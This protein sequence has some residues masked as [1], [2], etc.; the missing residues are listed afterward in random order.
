MVLPYAQRLL[1]DGAGRRRRR[2]L[3]DVLSLVPSFGDQL[4]GGLG[5]ALQPGQPRLLV[6]PRHLLTSGQPP[7]G[8]GMKVPLQLRQTPDLGAVYPQIGLD[9][10]RRRRHGGKLNPRSSAHRSSGAATGQGRV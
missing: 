8:I 1:A 7:V 9:M 3:V 2:G 4:L 6:H 10:G 5:L